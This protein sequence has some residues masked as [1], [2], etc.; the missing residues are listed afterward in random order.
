MLD[1]FSDVVVFVGTDVG[2]GSVGPSLGLSI[3]SQN[4]FFSPKD[5]FISSVLFV[6]EDVTFEIETESFLSLIMTV[7][8]DVGNLVG[9]DKPET[10]F[11][12]SKIT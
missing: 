8:V 1:R 10:I 11:F 7:R 9:F 3:D 6:V 4:S 5:R 12:L 2:S